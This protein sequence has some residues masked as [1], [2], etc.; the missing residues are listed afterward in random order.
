MFTEPMAS[1][2]QCWKKSARL[3][4][5]CLGLLAGAAGAAPAQPDAAEGTTEVLF[6]PWDDAEGALV[7]LV[8]EARH[9]IRVQI[10]LFTSRP[11]ARAL[12]AAHQRGVRV[13]VLADREMVEKGENSQIPALHAAGIPVWLEVRYAAAHNKVL[14][15][16]AEQG[17]AV[18]TGSYNY[19]YSAQ[20][21]NAENLLILR[22]APKV[23]G[24]Y[25]D[26]WKRHRLD[27]VSFS[28]KF[29]DK[30]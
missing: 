25:F 16:D 12:V 19:T 15:V 3:L 14:L 26:N 5:L 4:L 7:N 20:A 10:Y 13:E 28:D 1:M 6:T 8:Q 9:S 27:A 11:L 17:G 22:A 30:P 2:R 29:G 18:A 21:R 24:A 23:I